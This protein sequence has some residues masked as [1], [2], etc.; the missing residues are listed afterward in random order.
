M[1]PFFDAASRTSLQ[2]YAGPVLV[3]N[4]NICVSPSFE[5]ASIGF[6]KDNEKC[7]ESPKFSGTYNNGRVALG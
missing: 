1:L 2:S 7:Q 6:G 5:D 4:T 3:I